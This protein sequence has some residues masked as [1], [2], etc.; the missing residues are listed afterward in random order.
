MKAD[1]VSP[2]GRLSLLGVSSTGSSPESTPPVAKVRFSASLR[3]ACHLWKV[4]VL[5]AVLEVFPKR[6]IKYLSNVF[7]SSK[8]Q[9]Y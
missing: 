5:Q 2:S 6:T 3:S 7:K 8:F 1:R 9:V 4:I